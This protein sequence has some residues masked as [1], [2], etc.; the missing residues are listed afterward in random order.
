[1]STFANLIPAVGSHWRHG[2]RGVPLHLRGVELQA[3][4]PRVGRA[5]DH[6]GGVELHAVARPRV[7]VIPA[8]VMI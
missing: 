3:G 8:K 5:R 1:M 4:T 2:R 6:S 7:V